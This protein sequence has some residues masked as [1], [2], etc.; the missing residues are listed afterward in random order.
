MRQVLP[1]V[2]VSLVFFAA[3]GLCVIVWLPAK[4]RR[5]LLPALPLIGAMAVELALHLT[6][7]VVG[8][9]LGLPI[10][11]G[12]AVMLVLVRSLREAWWRDLQTWPWLLASITVGAVFATIMLLPVHHLGATLFGSFDSFAYVSNAAWLI[13]HPIVREPPSNQPVW[14]Y[15]QLV[16]VVGFRVGEELNQAAM[17]ILTGHDPRDSFYSV[18]VAWL[19]MLPGGVV[20]A[21]S[22]VRI[23][24]ITGLI[25]GAASTGSYLVLY[26]VS[27]SNSAG[28]LG[29]AMAPLAIAVVARFADDALHEERA[30]RLPAWSAAAA[31][32]ALASTY[33]EFLPLIAF[34]LAGYIL[35]RAPRNLLRAA[36]A[37]GRLAA[38]SVAVAPLGWWRAWESLRTTTG[39]AQGGLPPSPF[40]GYSLG[41]VASHYAGTRML[42]DP[43]PSRLGEAITAI[44][45]VGA[46]IGVIAGPARRFLAWMMASVVGSIV[47]LSTVHYFPYGQGRAVEITAPIV[48]LAAAAGYSEGVRRLWAVPR[49]RVPSAAIAAASAA[50]GVAFVVFGTRTVEPALTVT[51]SSASPTYYDRAEYDTAHAWVERNGG[52]GGSNAMVLGTQV[53]DTIWLEYRMRDLPGVYFPFVI[54]NYDSGGSPIRYFDGRSRPYAVVESGLAMTTPGSSEATH[55]VRFLLYMAGMEPDAIALGT[56][57][58]NPVVT[59]GGDSA[60][61]LYGVNGDVLIFHAPG[62]RAVTLQFSTPARCTITVGGDDNPQNVVTL[63]PSEVARVPVMLP[64]GS[65][66]DVRV[67]VLGSADCTDP[68]KLPS[69]V[70]IAEG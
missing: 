1:I 42:F 9:R 45:L 17:A 16:I 51:A 55:D 63:T 66:L 38:V 39:I 27:N 58:F 60:Q 20:A 11:G 65:A 6:G 59:V 46:L 61:Q 43:Q 69:L 24:R 26:Q 12:L 15:T 50:T 67:T 10:V 5:A 34:G 44:I 25:A 14:G 52:P 64:A 54:R 8:V 47:V 62:A 37:L 18:S 3:V 53:F 35:V 36:V 30:A 22:V 19:V 41:S 49:A 21:A 33:T 48:I 4:W 28:V 23:P 7:I 70:G 32:G 2:A 31:L 13:D 57:G 29:I 68:A 40:L 56:V